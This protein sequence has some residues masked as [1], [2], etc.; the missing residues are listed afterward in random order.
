[1]QRRAHIR[2]ELSICPVAKSGQSEIGQ[3]HRWRSGVDALR[4]SGSEM[5]L[6][7]RLVRVKVHVPRQSI[8]IFEPKNGPKS[9]FKPKNGPKSI[10]SDI[11]YGAVSEVI[12][13]FSQTMYG[14]PR[15][16][17]Y[18]VFESRPRTRLILWK[19]RSDSENGPEMDPSTRARARLSSKG[20]KFRILGPPFF[21]RLLG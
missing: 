18:A 3:E 5:A 15:S 16:M 11:S 2:T 7:S 12:V 1:M 6:P 21:A 17:V 10:F 9:I 14:Q 8:S 4:E 20:P 19:K 13:S